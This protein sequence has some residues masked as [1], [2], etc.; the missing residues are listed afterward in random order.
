[1]S[2]PLKLYRCRVATREGVVKTWHGAHPSRPALEAELQRQGFTLIAM[3]SPFWA[4]LSLLIARLQKPQS[5]ALVVLFQH[6][7]RLTRTGFVLMPALTLCIDLTRH[8]A[9]KNSLIQIR[10][11]LLHGQRLSAAMAI[12]APQIFDP[13]LRAFIQTSEETGQLEKGFQN[14]L[15]HLRQQNDFREKLRAAM[16]YPVVM[17]LTLLG[18]LIFFMEAFVPEM[19]H[20]TG[21]IQH[22]PD[23]TLVGVEVIYTHIKTA[24]PW[25]ITAGLSGGLTLGLI[26]RRS[27][28]FR[29]ALARFCLKIPFVGPHIQTMEAARFLS[30]FALLFEQKQD[31]LWGL[32]HARHVVQNAAFKAAIEGVGAAIRHGQTMSESLAKTGLF[33]PLVL[34]TIRLGEQTHLLAPSMQL[35][36]ENYSSEFDTW[37]Q[38]LSVWLP[39]IA[40]FLGGGMILLLAFTCLQP[41]YG[42]FNNLPL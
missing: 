33:P 12:T 25:L 13:L 30:A 34:E 4:R 20:F 18:V 6:L 16:R 7:E 35:L 9:L 10:A 23:A 21:H 8:R 14:C 3:H 17:L 31:V 26:A 22:A 19:R 42:L 29:V 32:S 15:L 37:A 27:P 40:T 2:A 24:L 38:K 1:M 28:S 41:L 5:D 36:A 11:H 39:I